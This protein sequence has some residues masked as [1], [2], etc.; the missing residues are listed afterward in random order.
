MDKTEVDISSE[1]RKELYD[2]AFK[3]LPTRKRLTIRVCLAAMFVI[4]ISLIRVNT[5]YFSMRLEDNPNKI[6]GIIALI[7]VVAAALLML[8]LPLLAKKRLMRNLPEKTMVCISESELQVN[9]IRVRRQ[10]IVG[11]L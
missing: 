1:E 4:S 2:R 8:L 5:N 6:V 9:Q 7:F 11:I 3:I 10:D